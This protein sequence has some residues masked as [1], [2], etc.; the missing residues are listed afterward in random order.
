VFLCA[1]P[2]DLAQLSKIMRVDHDIFGK[3]TLSRA[4][5]TAI[6]MKRPDT[7]AALFAADGSVAGYLDLYPLEPASAAQFIDGEICEED[8]TPKMILSRSESHEGCCF[9]AGSIVV[10]RRYDPITKSM[11]ILGLFSWHAHHIATRIAEQA[12]IVMTT[13]TPHGARLAAKIRAEKLRD[14]AQRKDGLDLFGLLVTP[15]AL[16]QLHSAFSKL[17]IRRLIDLKFDGTP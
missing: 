12:I 13:V 9:Y 15:A 17:E 8:F 14:G 1:S 5:S 10:D 7:Y 16:A 6:F 11:M 2:R 3:G 4:A